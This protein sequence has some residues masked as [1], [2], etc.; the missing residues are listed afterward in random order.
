VNESIGGYFGL[1]LACRGSYHPNAIKLNTARNCLDYIL[2]A[3][4]VKK[5][6]IPY[7]TCDVLL[8]KIIMN[9]VEYCYYHINENFEPSETVRLGKNE[10]F[11]YTNYFGLKSKCINELFNIYRESLIVDNSQ[12]FYSKPLAFVDTFYSAR[13]FFGVPDGGYL[14]TSS[15]LNVDLEQSISYSSMF[16]LLKRLDLSPEDGY[17]ENKKHEQMLNFEPLKMMS[18]LTEKILASI[19]YDFVK[20]R[21]KQNYKYLDK[22]LGKNNKILFHMN[23]EDVPMVYPFY[24]ENYLT[25]DLLIKNKVYSAQ[26]WES[27]LHNEY[28]N[29]FERMISASAVFFPIDQRYDTIDLESALKRL[30]VI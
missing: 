21:R 14:Y 26:Y 10:L 23:E 16:H 30:E 18:K 24:N 3:R 25:R 6:F 27:V 19:D 29:Y 22:I 4:K 11:I 7:Y 13:K 15:L 12:A 8:K 20:A 1:E 28:C 17:L 2:K 9:N 5:V